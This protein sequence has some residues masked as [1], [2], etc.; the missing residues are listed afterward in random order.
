MTRINYPFKKVT[1]IFNFFESPY[2]VTLTNRICTILYPRKLKG[3]TKHQGIP[4]R[5]DGGGGEGTGKT[6]FF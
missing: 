3:K 1:F 4:I 5:A 2:T 6:L